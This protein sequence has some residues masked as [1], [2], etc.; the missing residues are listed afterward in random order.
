MR[1]ELCYLRTQ[2]MS[3]SV[4]AA[5]DIVMCY[6]WHADPRSF[7]FNFMHLLTILTVEQ[8]HVRTRSVPSLPSPAGAVSLESFS[9]LFQHSQSTQCMQHF[10]T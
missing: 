2:Q 7:C 8:V 10:R 9:S 4:C 6:F 1:H 3:L 5:H